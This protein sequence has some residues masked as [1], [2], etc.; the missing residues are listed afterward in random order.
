MV[1]TACCTPAVFI[2]QYFCHVKTNVRSAEREGLEGSFG[3]WGLCESHAGMP[4]VP[5]SEG[6]ECSSTFLS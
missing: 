1:Y 2:Y 3:I 6:T 5:E 4:N